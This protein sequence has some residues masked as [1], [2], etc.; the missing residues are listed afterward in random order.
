[1]NTDLQSLYNT[2]SPRSRTS[3]IEALTV[4]AEIEELDIRDLM[5]Q[6]TAVDNRDILLVYNNLLSAS[7]NHLRAFVKVLAQQGQT[8]QPKY[9]SR[10]VYDS[11]IGS[12]IEQGRRRGA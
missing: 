7:R 10:E 8:Y 6:I 3:L 4:G 2:F 9:L 1:M 5:N 12:A 11:I